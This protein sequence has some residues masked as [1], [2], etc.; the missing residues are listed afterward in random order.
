MEEAGT[1]DGF[2]IRASCLDP[3]EFQLPGC[4]D[5]G[6]FRAWD[7]GFTDQIFNDFAEVRK[8]F[9]IQYILFMRSFDGELINWLSAFMTANL[10]SANISYLHVHLYMWQSPTKP[11]I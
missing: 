11:Q 7:P 5:L 9:T 6:F 8:T 3:L 4:T 1:F 2:V 10:K